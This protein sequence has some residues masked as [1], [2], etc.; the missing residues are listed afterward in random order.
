MFKTLKNISVWTYR[1]CTSYIQVSAVKST[2]LLVK[3]LWIAL[4]VSGAI[5]FVI[6]DFLF[7]ALSVATIVLSLLPFLL[8]HK[9]NLN[10][11]RA[12]LVAIVIFIFSAIVLGQ[13]QG[14]YDT[15]VWWDTMLH[16]IAGTIFGLLGLVLQSLYGSPATA[17]R[18]P[19]SFVIMSLFVS[20]GMAGFWELFEWGMDN[21]FQTSMQNGGNQDT[22]T[23]MGIYL[24]GAL[25]ATVAGYLYAVGV[26]QHF[27]EPL[28]NVIGSV[29]TDYDS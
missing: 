22:M 10:F 28:Q 19:L 21:G 27:L 11:P 15:F 2:P 12:Y 4:L 20:M 24:V 6:G 7:F 23:D 8:A 1:V 16:G 17:K 3:L 18:K 26:K 5:S 14:F 9:H 25:V 29:D 13:A